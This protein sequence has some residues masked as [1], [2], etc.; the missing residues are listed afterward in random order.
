MNNLLTNRYVKYTLKGI[1]TQQQI[2]KMEM[3]GMDAHTAEY[4]E[5]AK[6]E[7]E[8]RQ[9][10]GLFSASKQLVLSGD[11]QVKEWSE[12]TTAAML[13]EARTGKDFDKLV[14]EHG[15]S[16]AVNSA[17]AATRTIV[18][19]ASEVTNNSLDW[20]ADK[21]MDWATRRTNR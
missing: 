4:Q 5:A 21:V 19:K 3:E 18:S 7:Y 13:I 17:S 12:N 1:I 14:V 9:I 16:K 15:R 2:I 10:L 11:L 20:V 6:K 8:L